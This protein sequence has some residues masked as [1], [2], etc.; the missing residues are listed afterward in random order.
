MLEEAL[1]NYSITVVGSE[2]IRHNEN[3]TYKIMGQNQAYILRIHKPIEGFN[4][5]L[6]RMGK[7]ASIMI[8]DEMILLDT[9]AKKTHL[10]TQR[11]VRNKQ[12][13]LVTILADGTPATLMEWVDGCTLEH[14]TLTDAICFDLGVMIAKM[15][16]GLDEIS[17]NH[18][19]RYDGELLSKMVAEACVAYECGHFTK[20]QMEIIEK[21]LVYIQDYLNENQHRFTLVHSDLSLS[22]LIYQNGTIIPIDFSLSGMSVPEMDLASVYS[23]IKEREFHR[24][25]GN[26]YES[27]LG[28]C[29][30]PKGIEICCCLQILLF[31]VCQHNGVAKETW[32][33][34]A[35]NRW[36]KDF[37]LP[38]IQME[39]SED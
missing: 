33:A 5:G 36:C 3:M 30:D 34:D 38:L 20:E 28:E 25:I 13:Q 17:L 27:I 4:L 1:S 32:F 12:D 10:G 39:Q 31:V 7:D 23:H 15:H 16:Q 21:T 35:L 19:Y 2:L 22:N 11:V 14:E 6:L 26:G 9:L 8:E 29:L 18:R 37:F 24:F